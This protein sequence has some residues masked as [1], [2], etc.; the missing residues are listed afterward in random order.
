ML[1]PRPHRPR[2]HVRVPRS[3]DEPRRE[4]FYWRAS[5]GGVQNFLLDHMMSAAVCC[6]ALAVVTIYST[7]TRREHPSLALA[8]ASAAIAAAAPPRVEEAPPV[9]AAIG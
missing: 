5:R 2:V 4:R 3:H 6:L 8:P 7:A 1:A 9:E